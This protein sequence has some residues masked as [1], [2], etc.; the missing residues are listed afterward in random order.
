LSEDLMSI[1]SLVDDDR[2][3]NPSSTQEAI[4]QVRR[5][6]YHPLGECFSLQSYFIR[7]TSISLPSPRDQRSS[8]I[9]KTSPSPA[10]PPLLTRRTGRLIL[11]ATQRKMFPN[12][13]ITP[14]RNV[15]LYC[16]TCPSGQRSRN[17]IGR[18]RIMKISLYCPRLGSF[19]NS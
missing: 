12:P 4:A 13:R 18:S 7:L 11:F 14:T 17:C 5:C 16:T 8:R 9:S 1:A 10:I 19:L 3:T 15:M 2:T 6:F